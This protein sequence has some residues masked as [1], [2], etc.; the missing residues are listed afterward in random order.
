MNPNLDPMVL[1]MET[2]SGQKPRNPSIPKKSQWKAKT[3]R[4]IS[5][6]Q[7]LPADLPETTHLPAKGKDPRRDLLIKAV[8]EV[9]HEEH[10]HDGL[11]AQVSELFL[12]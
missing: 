7:I 4:K 3:S 11:H 12:L 1:I 6:M 5:L 8:D 10:L 2:R 9:V